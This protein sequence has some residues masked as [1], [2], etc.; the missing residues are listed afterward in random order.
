[1]I[2]HLVY[3]SEKSQHFSAEDI[4]KIIESSQKN[5]AQMK[6]TGLLINNGKF[7]IQLLEGRKEDVM[8]A[9][10]RISLD[11]RHFRIKIVFNGQSESRLFPEW[12]MGLVREP[13]ENTMNQ[14][15]PKLHSEL[16]SH[17]EVRKKIQAA[18]KKFNSK[19]LAA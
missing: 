7:F 19:T 6:V 13:T 1:M 5:N 16:Q 4:D 8:K 2:F 11:N 18:L 9:F 14:I 12:A 15:L 10:H 17:E 3:V